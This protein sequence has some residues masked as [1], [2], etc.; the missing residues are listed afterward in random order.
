MGREEIRDNGLKHMQKLAN[1]FANKK[2]VTWMAQFMADTSNCDLT[3]DEAK[4][5]FAQ[6][7]GKM[8]ALSYCM[9]YQDAKEKV[10]PKTLY[11]PR[12]RIYK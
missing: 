1:L 8:L 3:T 10:E 7:F 11:V 9:G 5:K 6:E 12:G 2:V 4:K